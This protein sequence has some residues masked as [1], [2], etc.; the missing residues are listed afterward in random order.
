MAEPL[1]PLKQPTLLVLLMA[2]LK[3]AAG[4]VIVTERVMEQL[5]ASVTVQVYVP[6]TS[7]VAVALLCTGA[8]FQ[9]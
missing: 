1:L 9:A 3:A 8:V 6:A 7:V 4:C 2:L 5:F